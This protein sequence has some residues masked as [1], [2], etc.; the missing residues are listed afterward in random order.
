MYNQFVALWNL[1]PALHFPQAN[2]V[3][4]ST[5]QGSVI[6][7]FAVSD[8]NGSPG[9]AQTRFN[10][11]SSELTNPNSG[12]SQFAA[13]N[14]I[15]VTSTSQN[16]GG[17]G[18]G[19]SIGL[20]IGI[21]IGALVLAA[22]IVIVAVILVKRK[23]E[24]DSKYTPLLDVK[25][26]G[27]DNTATE[28]SIGAPFDFKHEHGESKMSLVSREDAA[29]NPATYSVGTIGKKGKTQRFR[30]IAEIRDVGEGVL[31]GYKA[32]TL[33]T[34]EASDLSSAT[35]WVWATMQDGRSGWTPLNHTGFIN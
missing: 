24:S 15:P 26:G 12:A 1:D 28:H 8:I 32:G 2:I 7:N 25:R 22:I 5:S 3:L 34:I 17:G 29:K 35:D 6:A 33:G 27:V 21:V 31:T 11:L 16:G 9:S 10:Q 19:P 23:R 30:L 14:G 20:I 13:N 4:L 18:G